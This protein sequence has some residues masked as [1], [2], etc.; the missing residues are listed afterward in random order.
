MRVDP[1]RA[2]VIDRVMATGKLAWGGLA[3]QARAHLPRVPLLCF[4]PPS[5]PKG[6]IPEGALLPPAFVPSALI[7]PLKSFAFLTARGGTSPLVAQVALT[8]TWNQILTE[9]VAPMNYTDTNGT[10]TITGFVGISLSWARVS[11]GGERAA[12]AA[13]RTLPLHLDHRNR[14]LPGNPPPQPPLERHPCCAPDGQRAPVYRLP[15]SHSL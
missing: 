15:S 13:A 6:I 11:D 14:T 3:L 4:S 7:S 1:L 10:S 8:P 2:R 5:Q 9:L 12:A